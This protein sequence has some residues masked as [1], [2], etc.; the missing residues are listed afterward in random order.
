[1]GNGY[2]SADGQTAYY[3]Q[4]VAYYPYYGAAAPKSLG[5]PKPGQCV[6]N[7][8]DAGTG[9]K[10][11]SESDLHLPGTTPSLTR[12]YNSQW[13]SD[14]GLGFGWTIPFNKHL[15]IW[16]IVQLRQGDGRGVPFTCSS[17]VCTGDADTNLALT[18][19][20]SGY[21]LT[22]R[23]NATDRFDTTGK[24]RSETSPTGQTTVYGYNSSGRLNTVTDAF[25]HALTFVQDNKNHFTSVTDPAGNIIYYDYDDTYPTPVPAIPIGN[26]TRV[27]FP[28]GTAKIYYYEDA[29][30]PH[31]LTGISFV[32]S[33]GVAT[34]YSTYAYD[35][36][37]KAIRTEHAQTDNGAPQEKFTLNYNSDTQT[38]VTDPVGMNEV[39]TF[40]T[41]L[42][43]KNLVTKT[44]S[45]DTKSL[46]QA[47]D[48]NNNL[49]CRK[50]EENRVTLYNYN[51]TNQKLSTT[52]GLSGS[53]CNTCLTNPASCAS[54]N[55][56]SRLTTYQYL[57]T[58]L[59]LPTLIE[60][61]SVAGDPH[62]KRITLSY[63]DSR[64]PALPT[65]ITQSGFTPAGAS[66]SRTVSLGYNSYG[67]VISINGP[68]T[69]VSDITTLEYYECTTGGA[70]GQLKKVTNA[71]GHITTY[72]LYDANG[73]LLQMT[74]PAKLKTLYTYDAR[75]R[76]KTLTRVPKAGTQTAC[77]IPGNACWQYSYTPWGDVS[78]VTDPDGVVLNYIYDAAH[79]LKT[80]IDG[81]G[82]AIAYSYDLKGNRT[83]EVRGAN[84][85]SPYT[86]D[87]GY[88]LRNHVNYINR[89]GNN[90]MDLV[91][92]A[93]GNLTS[94]T[95]GN[96]NSTV[97]QYDALNRLFQTTDAMSGVTT[98]GHDR[99]DQ[100]N[101]V[102][103]PLSATT[104]A[105]TQYQYDD[106][107]NA[108]QETSP[109]RGTLRYTYDEAGNLLTVIDGRGMGVEYTYD[110]L[111]RAM[112]RYSWDET[113]DYFT[114]LYDS[115]G[116]G[117]LCSLSRNDA[118]HMNLSYDALGRRN[119]ELSF[120]TDG[121]Y[122]QMRYAYSAAG[123]LTQITYPNGVKINYVYNNL[124]QAQ[125]V[126]TLVGGVTTTL[127]DT[128]V[129][130]PFGP[131]SGWS[132]GNGSIYQAYFDTAY[133]PTLL[134]DS[135][136]F[137]SNVYDGVGNLLTLSSSGQK[138][139]TYD[140]LD[141]LTQATDSQAGS[142]GTLSWGYDGNGNRLRET[143]NG[144]V[145][146]YSYAAYTN[147]MYTAGGGDLRVP[148]AAGQ[149]Q[150]MSSLGTLGYDGYGQLTEIASRNASY[151]YDAF[152]RRLAKTVNT[153]TTHF[154]YG[155]GGELLYETDGTT[156]K[157][158]VYLENRPL[159]RVDNGSSLYYYHTDH[160]G[161]PQRMTDSARTVVWAARY[162][163]FGKGT[164][165]VNT[166]T[167]NVRLAGMYCD[168]ETSLCIAGDRYYDPK[169]GR[170]IT[171]DRMS[172]AWHVE[173]WK[174]NMGKSTRIPL[175]ANPYVYVANNPLRWVDRTGR[176]LDD[177]EPSSSIAHDPIRWGPPSGPFGPLCGPEDKPTLA[178]WIPD[179]YPEACQTHD[180]CYEDCSK[181]KQQC[182]EEFKRKTS[183]LPGPLYD[184]SATQTKKSQEQFDK[185]RTKCKCQ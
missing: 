59:D 119:Y 47:F 92:D 19:D 80:I 73:R 176:F 74:D 3:T 127:A 118:L 122:Q 90:V 103:A 85:A 155:P 171:A 93:V 8:C 54:P 180:K 61:P 110:A 57:S 55:N 96:Y 178:T 150:Y 181:T 144:T 158:Y 125:Q 37:G 10:Y 104:T 32:D 38:T 60:S 162:E 2:S 28:D 23:D 11:Q 165:T 43:V 166:I 100:V 129:H 135:S 91:H 159:A 21:T 115:C 117:R 121:S 70:C 137:Q 75:G 142:Y 4:Y 16:F 177:W 184:Y 34:R 124:G 81:A 18:K 179:I 167:N 68:R 33:S 58:T 83:G 42:G 163:P 95:D 106:L 1:M 153:T 77:A 123:R 136:H 44:S 20:A 151:E 78:R 130:Q 174:A 146:N 156:T 138:S 147:W 84:G 12:S 39:M 99:N 72:D 82:N 62:K 182:D 49:T 86:V 98:Y 30:N 108:L 154:A 50:D 109:D 87:Y 173:R 120:A 128:I 185:S 140:P 145:Q 69:D 9:N 111:N 143:R 114:Y 107:G 29:N 172:I 94:V 71:L 126:T 17:N 76:L 64:F 149:T 7:P 102:I 51:N 66:V 168:P 25:G 131:P 133:Q 5:A 31:S 24:L 101:Q 112:D 65:A 22:Y 105:T 67:Q 141:R 157:A 15:G 183:G 152:G 6:S 160:L 26:L 40:T 134:S 79:D 113:T 48:A 169:S 161:T 53:D 52:E 56:P 97:H 63:G 46:Q 41:N 88:D 36:T 45:I 148:D 164:V 27:R 132:Y 14:V 13:P 175:E 116:Q 89:G 139:F 35:T 170:W